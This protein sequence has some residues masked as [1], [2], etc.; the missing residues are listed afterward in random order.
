[1]DDVDRFRPLP[2]TTERRYFSPT[3]LRDWARSNVAPDFT[4][5]ALSDRLGWSETALRSVLRGDT[6]P[7]LEG[8]CR[9][10]SRVGEPVGTWLSLR[11]RQK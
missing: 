11:D 4:I 6:S 9:A 5:S 10:L 3:L 2:I 1:M 7:T 8:Y